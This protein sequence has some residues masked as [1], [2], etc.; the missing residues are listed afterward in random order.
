MEPGFNLGS[1]REVQGFFR[2]AQVFRGRSIGSHGGL[3][4]AGSNVAYTPLLG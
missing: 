1:D 4:E 3:A 2:E